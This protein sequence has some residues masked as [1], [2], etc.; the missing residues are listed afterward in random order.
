LPR[1]ALRRD[2][3]AV[4][5]GHAVAYVWQ[6]ACCVQPRRV[7]FTLVWDVTS[8]WVAVWWVQTAAPPTP[9]S[10]L[11]PRDTLTHRQASH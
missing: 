4:G 10:R 6:L 8:M 9:P 2:L 5:R 11:Q 3:L 1:P 7:G